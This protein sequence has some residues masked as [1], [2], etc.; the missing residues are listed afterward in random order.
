MLCFSVQMI[1]YSLL[2]KLAFEGYL[3]LDIVLL[4]LR[5]IFL[6]FLFLKNFLA[7]FVIIWVNLVSNF[8]FK[9][10]QSTVAS[11]LWIVFLITIFL[12]I[13]T[14]MVIRVNY[15][16]YSTWDFIIL[17]LIEQIIC[18]IARILLFLLIFFFLFNKVRFNFVFSVKSIFFKI[19][20]F[21]QCSR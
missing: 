12:L 1:R 8:I 17:N 13:W 20:L 18:L 6:L 16:L 4:L 15:L 2:L 7:I 9:V 21:F 5:E 10:V 19:N 3:R 11:S 14:E